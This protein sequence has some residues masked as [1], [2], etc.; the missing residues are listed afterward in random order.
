MVMSNK[1]KTD[2][3]VFEII[4]MVPLDGFELLAY[5]THHLY[6]YKKIAQAYFQDSLV[7]ILSIKRVTLELLKEMRPYIEQKTESSLGLP[8]RTAFLM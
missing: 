2:N 3:N 1:H 6:L 5:C 4:F 7:A 8:A